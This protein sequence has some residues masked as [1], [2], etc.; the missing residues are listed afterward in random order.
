MTFE[1]DFV[2][3][4]LGLYWCRI[5]SLQLLMEVKVYENNPLTLTA[6]PFFKVL[7]RAVREY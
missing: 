5:N 4:I 1:E 6:F 3:R 7:W 2:I